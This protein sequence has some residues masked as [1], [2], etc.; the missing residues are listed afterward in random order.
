MHNNAS[1][2]AESWRNH[3]VFLIA[4]K[5]FKIYDEIS[6]GSRPSNQ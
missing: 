3:V 4:L 1:S 6:I 5:C 2:N